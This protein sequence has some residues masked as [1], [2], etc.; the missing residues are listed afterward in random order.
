M[1]TLKTFYALALMLATSLISINQVKA[2]KIP[3]VEQPDSFNRIHVKG[4]VEV[5]LIQ[6]DKFGLNYAESNTGVV[7]VIQ[8][9]HALTISSN[10]FEPAK[11][12]VYVDENFFRISAAENATIH[13]EGKL[14]LNYL[15]LFLKDHSSAEINSQTKGLYTVISDKS[16]LKLIGLTQDHNLVMGKTPKLNTSDFVAL[17][18]TTLP[19]SENILAA[20]GN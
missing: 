11:L 14:Q 1:K 6:R 5:T 17:K 9:G 13:T 2:Q 20:R 19:I 12:I 3:R 15:Q 4:N 10:S 7:K 18:L 16:M 8:Q